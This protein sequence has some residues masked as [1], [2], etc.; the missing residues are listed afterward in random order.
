M[1]KNPYINNP[2]PYPGGYPVFSRSLIL[3]G[4]PVA[5]FFADYFESIWQLEKT[6]V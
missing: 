5:Y 1:E 2:M 6:L 4:Y 3:D